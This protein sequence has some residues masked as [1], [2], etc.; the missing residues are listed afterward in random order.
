MNDRDGPNSND[1]FVSTARRS[2]KL[3]AAGLKVQVSPLK[4]V[5]A[6]HDTASY[7]PIQINRDV[8][9]FTIGIPNPASRDKIDLQKF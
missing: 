9:R 5:L 4:A 8:L 2:T 3:K 7:P 6:E 1:M